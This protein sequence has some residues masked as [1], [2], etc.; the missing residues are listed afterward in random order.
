MSVQLTAGQEMELAS[1][2]QRTERTTDEVAQEA[3][4][5]FLEASAEHSFAIARAREQIRLG[6]TRSH[7]E[8]FAQLKQRMGW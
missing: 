4:A 7:E 2:A 5:R 6:Q 3:V 1:I 8:V